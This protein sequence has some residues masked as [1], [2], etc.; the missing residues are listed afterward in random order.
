MQGLH[1]LVGRNLHLTVLIEV[2]E[3]FRPAASPLVKES[4]E[5]AEGGIERGTA[6]G[7]LVEGCGDDGQC[8]ALRTT[9][10]DGILPVPL[11]Q[12]TEEVEDTGTAD[13]DVLIIIGILRQHTTTHIAVALLTFHGI[14]F[15]IQQLVVVVNLYL[16]I[17][18]A[19]LGEIVRRINL[20]TAGTGRTEDDGIFGA[21]RCKVRGTRHGEI[22]LH[23]L[24]LTHAQTD[25]PGYELV[26]RGVGNVFVLGL[27]RHLAR[28]LQR[29]LPELVEI[30]RHRREGLDLLRGIGHLHQVFLRL[31]VVG[32]ELILTGKESRTRHRSHR[33]GSL[34]VPKD[35]GVVSL[36]EKH[37]RPNL[38]A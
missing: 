14:C 8:P 25:E 4:G 36:G 31:T 27:E 38:V 13:I 35:D 32:T 34:T 28:F 24:V 11:R 17:D 10:D 21:T 18:T 1:S 30:L 9:G 37:L 7:L 15:I 2:T 3:K 5:V 20:L 33:N 16:H 29:R 23:P 6:C 12:C 19:L 26:V 22:A